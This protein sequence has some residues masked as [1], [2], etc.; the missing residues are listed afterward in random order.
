MPHYQ[1]TMT[2]R[3]VLRKIIRDLE[4]RK[5]IAQRVQVNP[6]TLRRWAAG[7]TSPHW[8]EIRTLVAVVPELMPLLLRDLLGPLAPTDMFSL[9][10]TERV[11]DAGET[12]SDG[13][14]S[15]ET[16]I[17]SAFYT[18][19]LQAASE[20]TKRFLAVCNLVLPQVL[21][22]LDPLRL[23][24]EIVLAACMPPTLEGGK[25][26]SLRVCVSQGTPPWSNVVIDVPNLFL[27]SESLAGYSVMTQRSMVVR[28][29][30]EQSLVLPIKPM[31]HEVSS[32]T[33]PLMRENSTSGCLVVSSTQENYFTTERLKLIKDYAALVC[34]AFADA[35][36]FPL[37]QIALEVMPCW[38]VQQEHLA[39]LPKRVSEL[40][41]DTMGNGPTMDIFA[42]ELKVLK[43][44]EDELLSSQLKHLTVM[45]AIHEG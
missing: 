18:A 40:Q 7:D 14:Q 34:L 3:D 27:G 5:R 2:W 42:A 22:Q 19:V 35:Q 24:M 16:G 36:F 45:H 8:N 17:P 37:S 31:P 23:G 26:R 44:I 12:D 30:L 25:I 33:F 39:T 43:Q 20:R 13:E 38:E 28:N 29:V 1:T 21:R 9:V 10:A 4:E 15:L 41:N 6:E 32:A 11:S